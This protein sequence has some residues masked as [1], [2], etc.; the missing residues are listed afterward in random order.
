MYAFIRSIPAAALLFTASCASPGPIGPYTP[1]TEGARDSQLAERLTRQA[2]DLI[3]TDPEK[4]EELLRD[5]LTA[6]LFCG[7]AHVNLGVVQLRKGRLYEA[8]HEFEWARKLM[9]GHPDPR[10]NLGI[11]LE[12]GGR[13]DD[14]LASYQ[15][16]LEVYPGHLPAMQALARLQ[17][18]AER[19]DAGT[20]RL[21]EEIALN[22]ETALWRE[23][24]L[25]QQARLEGRLF[26][27]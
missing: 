10:L 13:I 19:A 3:E 5:A 9:P 1:I 27:Q 25:A 24:A 18:R 15:S 16:A 21:L 7:P 2:A 20:L 8:A 26:R 22:G 14:A 6:D 4:A 23:W 11:A 17:V 12:R